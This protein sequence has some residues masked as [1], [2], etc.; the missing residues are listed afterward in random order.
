MNKTI[1]KS[2]T[3]VYCLNALIINLFD[4]KGRILTVGKHDGSSDAK[5]GEISIIQ[6]SLVLCS[7]KVV[8]VTFKG[9][10]KNVPLLDNQSPMIAH[11]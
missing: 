5:P 7:S 10:K 8:H 1:K 9:Q 2:K 11:D 6:F 4:N 3:G